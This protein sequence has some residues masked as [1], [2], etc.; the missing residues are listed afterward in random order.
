MAVGAYCEPLLQKLGAEKITSIDAS[1]FEGAS[2]V[3]DFSLPI[4]SSLQE[5]FDTFLDFGSVEHI[6]DVAQVIDNIVKLVKPGG[7]I[8]IAT[9]ANGF[10]AHGL[11]Q[12]SPEFFYSVFSSRNGFQDTGVFLVP[13][14]NQKMWSFIRRPAEL[15]RRNEIP[16]EEQMMVLVFSRKTSDVAPLT[17][18]QSDYDDAW[19]KFETGD[20]K[21][22]NR[23][24]ISGW[25]KALH[26]FVSPYLYR[27][28]TYGIHSHQA[29][30]KFKAER[31]LVDP[32]VIDPGD[33]TRISHGS[34]SRRIEHA[35]MKLA[36]L[37]GGG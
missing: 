34:A 36:G 4:P 32:D 2:L 35:N 17:V 16:F 18:F 33:F 27:R 1:A 6:F 10:P 19:A 31:I 5:Q 12:Y 22:W 25:K 29:R 8:L 23:N 30:R 28:I 11:F 7:H 37:S 13:I 9:N 14:S 15:K 3:H 21:T 20:W 26:G 24:D